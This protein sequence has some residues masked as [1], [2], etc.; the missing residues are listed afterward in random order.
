MRSRSESEVRAY[1]L[2]RNCALSQATA[3]KKTLEM[4]RVGA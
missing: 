3:A 4:A 2:L 1:T